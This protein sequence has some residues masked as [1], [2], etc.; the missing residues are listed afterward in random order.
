MDQQSSP[1]DWSPERYWDYLH[2]LARVF[3]G[4]RQ[5]R[6]VS[7]SDLVQQTMLKAWKH[8]DQFRGET[9]EQW[10][11]WLRQILAH[12]IADAFRQQPREKVIQSLEQSSTQLE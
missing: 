1:H 6:G 11:A 5:R 10:R 3:V 2:L 9:E 8:Q 4:R 12:S 7:A